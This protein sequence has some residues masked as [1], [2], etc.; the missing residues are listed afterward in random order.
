MK[1]DISNIHSSILYSFVNCLSNFF[2]KNIF[3]FNFYLKLYSCISIVH[4]KLFE[5]IK[6]EKI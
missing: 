3:N 4:R 5:E 1:I 2:K 6:L